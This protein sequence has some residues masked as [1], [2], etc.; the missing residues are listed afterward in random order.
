MT[1]WKRLEPTYKALTAI[2]SAMALG[3]GLM[4]YTL[5]GRTEINAEAIL[6]QQ[7]V[8]D[9]MQETDY[10]TSAVLDTLKADFALVK[11][12]AKAEIENT[13]SRRCLVNGSGA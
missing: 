10:Q 1:W 3:M 9:E 7:S 12:W 4:A 2:L 5:G 6:S 13:D 11:C 8:M